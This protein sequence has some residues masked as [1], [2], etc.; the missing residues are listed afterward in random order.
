MWCVTTGTPDRVWCCSPLSSHAATWIEPRRDMDPE[1][2]GASFES[3]P[4]MAEQQALQEP[5]ARDPRRYE[6]QLSVTLDLH[7]ARRGGGAAAHGSVRPLEVPFRSLGHDAT[8]VALEIAL[9]GLV[10]VADPAPP[11]HTVRMA[12]EELMQ[13]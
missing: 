1:P 8:V 11:G 4:D 2:A 5:P 3:R 6:H 10:E 9:D 7:Q 13:A 12:L